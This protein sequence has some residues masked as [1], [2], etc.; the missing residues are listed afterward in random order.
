MEILDIDAMR[1]MPPDGQF[2]DFA[3]FVGRVV[4][5]LNFEQLRG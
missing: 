1:R 5:N 2:G 3:G 4:Q